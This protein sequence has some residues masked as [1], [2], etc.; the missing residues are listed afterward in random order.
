MVKN[1]AIIEKGAYTH[2]QTGAF[3][4]VK[5]YIVM[6]KAD[7]K[8]LLLQLTSSFEKAVD[9]VKI[10]LTQLDS[11]G[12]VISNESFV[13]DGF[14]INPG[15]NY[16]LD[17]GLVLDSACSD[18]RVHVV[19]AVSGEYRYF[20]RNGQSV[21]TYDPRGYAKKNYSYVNVSTLSSKLKFEKS[22]RIHSRIAWLASLAVLLTVAYATIGLFL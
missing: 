5:N 13:Y 9:G 3:I 12:N 16:A 14:T 4:Q 2:H 22:G 20:F 7:K 19:Y 18:F 6:R 17:S 11:A 21:Q 10:T 8:S 15:E 1:R